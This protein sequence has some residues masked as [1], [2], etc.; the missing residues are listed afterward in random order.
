VS[1]GWKRE[2][3][4]EKYWESLSDP[5]AELRS[6]DLLGRFDVAGSFRRGEETVGDLDVVVESHEKDIPH[7]DGIA[8]L[9][10]LAF[11]SR[12]CPGS[13]IRNIGRQSFLRWDR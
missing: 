2:H 7:P 4:D 3:V 1:N 9:L 13:R 10:R 6:R 11:E 12:C 5:L 8:E